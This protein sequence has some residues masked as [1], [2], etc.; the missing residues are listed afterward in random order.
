MSE[1][2]KE[3]YA[4]AYSGNQLNHFWKNARTHILHQE[5][6]KVP[7][8]GNIVDIGCGRGDEVNFLFNRGFNV[9]GVDMGG[10]EPCTNNIS[11]RLFLGQSSLDLTDEIRYETEMLLF[12]DVLE[13][14]ERPSVFL[15]QHYQAYPSLKWIILTLPARKELYSNY[16]KF[17]GHFKRY[18][19]KECTDLFQKH[20]FVKLS[21]FF[22]L[23]YVP[24]FI[25]NLLGVKR[26]T[27]INAPKNESFFH[28]IVSRLF[29][30]EYRIVPSSFFGSSLIA[31]ISIQY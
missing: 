21:Y 25:F 10:P 15:E 11:S 17:Y 22:H 30:Y 2:S 12:L 6:S 7:I 9:F 26:K 20:E 4:K 27:I 5:I 31:V 14:I 16:D 19:L 8:Q 28:K 18:S 24:A 23:M 3:Q 13:H 29:Q 1:F